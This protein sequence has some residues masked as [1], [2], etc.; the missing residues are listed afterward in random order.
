MEWEKHV[1]QGRDLLP[2]MEE[3]IHP[4][5]RGSPPLGVQCCQHHHSPRA[6]ILCLPAEYVNFLSTPLLDVS[7][8][9]SAQSS[10]P[11]PSIHNP[12]LQTSPPSPACSPSFIHSFIHCRH[13]YSAYSSCIG[14][15]TSSAFFP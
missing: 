6:L 4:L 15:Q 11:C 2:G 14:V 3:T 12:L 9:F 10:S 5:L 13:L 1:L 7:Q 8:P